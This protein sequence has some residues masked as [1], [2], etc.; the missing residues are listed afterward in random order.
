[1]F[2][3]VLLLI[4]AP[5]STIRVLS[6]TPNILGS[7]FVPQITSYAG[8]PSAAD[9]N[10]VLNTFMIIRCLFNGINSILQVALNAAWNGDNGANNMNGLTLAAQGTGAA[11]FSNIQVKEIIIRRSADNAAVQQQIYDYLRNA[12]GL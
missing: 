6:G 9:G 1:M 12:N 11:G 2:K 8:V 10:W 5:A 7:F 3:I 4:L